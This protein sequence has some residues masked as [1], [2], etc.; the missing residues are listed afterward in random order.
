MQIFFLREAK[1]EGLKTVL[2]L[3][4][5][6]SK[7]IPVLVCEPGCFS[8]LT[9]DLPD[10]IEDKDLAKRLDENVFMIDQ[11]LYQEIESGRLD[12]EFTSD[13]KEINLH[14]HCH[15]KHR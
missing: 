11:F 10:L 8:A 14:G 7:G 9:D 13:E 5:F 4:E 2:K 1:K 15:Q 3:D 12:V 6:M